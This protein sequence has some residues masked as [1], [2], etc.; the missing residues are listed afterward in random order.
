MA[1][2]TDFIADVYPEV[3]GAMDSIITSAVRKIVREF[4]RKT[5]RWRVDLPPLTLVLNQT[6]YVPGALATTLQFPVDGELVFYVNATQNGTPLEPTRKEDMDAVQFDW[7]I[8]QG[9]QMLRFY[10]SDPLTFNVYPIPVDVT[11][12]LQIRAAF[13]PAVAALTC[14]DFIMNDWQE[15]ITAGVVGR[16]LNMANRPWTDMKTAAV[17]RAE[18]LDGVAQAAIQLDRGF[19]TKVR[20]AKVP[21]FGA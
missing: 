10:P 8:E 21:F 16:L 20:T 3:D 6:A 2:I 5:T 11:Y 14:P 4:C 19:A 9:S 7:E 12:P 17:K 18:F 13:M 15:V 1:N